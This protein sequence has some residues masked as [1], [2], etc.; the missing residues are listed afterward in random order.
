MSNKLLQYGQQH[1]ALLLPSTKQNWF[2]WL[3]A[4]Y[5]PYI[6]WGISITV[7]WRCWLGGRKGIWPVKNWVVGCWWCADN[8]VI[9]L[10]QGANL[11]MAQLMPLPL[12]VSCLSKIQI[13]FRFWY[14]LT[15]VV[16]EKGSLNVRVSYNGLEDTPKIAPYSGGSR[17]PPNLWFFRLIWVHTP[18][19]ISI[20]SAVFVGLTAASKRHDTDT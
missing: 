13:G 2:C 4:R 14:Q 17:L 7:I 8:T 9:C 16:Q 6:Q 1:A 20:C 11:H 19:G 3:Q 18:S 10:E 5:S 15:Q 12:T